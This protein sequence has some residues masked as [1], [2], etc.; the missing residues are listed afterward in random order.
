M[1][2]CRVE[3]R[4]AYGVAVVRTRVLVAMA[5][6]AVVLAA[7]AL[8]LGEYEFDETLPIVAGPLLG[9]VVAEVVVSLGQ[10][11]SR[12]MAVM[13]AVG[14]GV[15]VVLAGHIDA[16]QVE[17]VKPGAYLSA[18]IAGLCAGARGWPWPARKRRPSKS[19]EAAS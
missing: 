17:A 9:L 7:G 11:R 19:A 12:T 14:T 1:R 3:R 18:T 10:H 2:R 6:G 15:S 4:S 16:N 5:I 13:L 8:F